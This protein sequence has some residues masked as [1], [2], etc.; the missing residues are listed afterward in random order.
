MKRAH[1]VAVAAVLV[2]LAAVSIRPL[3][4]YDLFWH[5]AAGREILST[6]TV[7]RVDP[8]SFASGGIPWIDHEWLWQVGAQSL[9][10]LA[11]GGR[12]PAPDSRGTAA[13]I[14]SGAGVV[15]AG[16][17]IALARFAR[18]GASPAAIAVLGL[19]AAETAR[20]RLAVRPESASLLLLSLFLACLG[21]CG[22]GLRRGF[23]LALVSAVWANVHPAVL[24]APFLALVHALGERFGAHDRAP[25][26]RHRD[27]FLVEPALI[28]AGTLA[29]PY[30]AALWSVPFKLASLVKS[31]TFFNPEWLPPPPER[32]PLFYATAIL[33]L[34]A[35]AASSIRTR[36]L[37]SGASLVAL[38][39]A[40]ISCRQMRH[41]GL[42]AIAALFAG[43]DLLHSLGAGSTL[44]RALSTRSASIVASVGAVL[45]AVPTTL[46][47]WQGGYRNGL[48]PGRFPVEACERIARN[49]RGVRLYNDVRFGGY[50]IWRFHPARKVFIDGRNEV[51]GGL[52]RRL[53]AIYSGQAPY[54][55]W[56]DLLRGYGI[57]GAIVRYSESL[58]GVIYPPETPGAERVRGYRAVSA[59]LFP[60]PEWALV[61]FDDTALVLMKRGGSAQAWIDDEGYRELNPE[62]LAYLLEKASRDPA[63][64]D[65]LRS[66][67]ERRIR[68]EPRSVRAEQCLVELERIA[69]GRGGGS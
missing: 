56:Q 64:A 69:R 19:L 59:F 18:T 24:I 7:P 42:F 4:A 52:L 23:A 8:F 54:S 61:Y 11:S 41:M 55:E 6:G 44:A 43:A 46:A 48:E 50:L 53:G 3:G 66:E 30:G 47:L 26:G 22:P 34:A 32:F 21:R 5:L 45:A 10:A 33:V 40:A 36:R 65:R 51:Y 20:D 35:A 27:A 17:F 57:D 25:H 16:F 67:A 68:E 12:G 28:A 38:L 2:Y 60:S 1:A 15:L 49:A 58:K 14:L 37:P 29:N 13:L 63:L 62:D 39:L 31:E 9:Y